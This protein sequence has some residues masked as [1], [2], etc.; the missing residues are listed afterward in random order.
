LEGWLTPARGGHDAST[1]HRP[2]ARFGSKAT[3]LVSL[4]WPEKRTSYGQ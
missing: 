4:Y 2:N 1:K 3:G